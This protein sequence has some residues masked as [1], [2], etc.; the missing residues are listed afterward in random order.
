MALAG[1]RMLFAALV[2]RACC[3][4]INIVS[5]LCLCLRLCST[6][7]RLV[8]T[9]KTL[10][11]YPKTED[12]IVL[13][14]GSGGV[15]SLVSLAIIALLFLSEL[16]SFLHTKTTHSVIVDTRSDDTRDSSN[17]TVQPSAE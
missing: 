12:E 16:W 5:A 13:K 8:R 9:L 10:D 14:T 2:P 1:Y 17:L 4:L 11:V 7:R 3:E 15:I 6:V